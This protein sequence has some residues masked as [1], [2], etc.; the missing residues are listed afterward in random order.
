MDSLASTPDGVEVVRLIGRVEEGGIE[1]GLAIS[2]FSNGHVAVIDDPG[3][4][5]VDLSAGESVHEVVA[6]SYGRRGS[7]SYGRMHGGEHKPI[8][9]VVAEIGY[10]ATRGLCAT[11]DVSRE[12]IEKVECSDGRDSVWRGNDS[13]AWCEMGTCPVPSNVVG[14]TFVRVGR[15]RMRGREKLAFVAVGDGASITSM[16][17]PCEAAFSIAGVCEGSVGMREISRAIFMA[18]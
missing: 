11:G 4:G 13:W 18:N 8:A 15:S 3:L 7:S 10:H 9:M 16:R 17:D 14:V 5:T 1:I 6:E 2:E 12:I